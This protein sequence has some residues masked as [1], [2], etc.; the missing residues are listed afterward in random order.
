MR[1]IQVSDQEWNDLK[2]ALEEGNN[3]AGAFLVFGPSEL[4]AKQAQSVVE[5]ASRRDDSTR[6]FFCTSGAFRIPCYVPFEDRQIESEPVDAA[7]LFVRRFNPGQ[8]P[9]QHVASEVI[10]A[11]V[12]AT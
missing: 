9:S 7:H 2:F 12:Q 4:V 6:Y 8:T 3:P 5:H 1:L 11:L 10:N